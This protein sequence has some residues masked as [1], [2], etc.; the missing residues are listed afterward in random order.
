MEGL[1]QL[2]ITIIIAGLICWLLLWL[3]DYAGVPEPFHKIGKVVIVAVAVIFICYALLG[4]AG[5]RVPGP[6]R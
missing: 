5:M 6:V 1:I 2:V 4:V 3:I